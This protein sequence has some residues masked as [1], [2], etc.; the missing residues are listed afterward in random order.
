MAELLHRAV[1]SHVGTAT[2]PL[3]VPRGARKWRVPAY[4]VADV[5]DELRARG[6][7]YGAA[8]RDAPP[9]PGPPRARSRWSAPATPPTTACTTPSLGPRRCAQ[10]AASLWPAIDAKAVLARLLS[11]PACLASH[12]DGVLTAQEQHLLSGTTLPAARLGARWSAADQVLLDELADLVERTPSLG[13]VIL[14]EAQDLSPMQCARSGD[15]APPGRRRCSATSPRAPPRG[16][17]SPGRTPWSFLGKPDA[18]IDVLDRGFRVPA[19][20]I[21]Y[22]ARLLPHMAPGLGTPQSVRDNPGRLLVEQVPAGR[23][24][25]AVVA[26]TTA[27]ATEPGTVGVIVADREVA[28][29]S[30]AL[31]K[32]GVGHGM[33]GA[34]RGDVEHQIDLVPATVAKGLEFDRVIVVEPT[35]IAAAEPDERTGLRRLYVVL[36]RAVSALHVLHADDLPTPLRG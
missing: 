14:D 22:A 32:A 31:T 5:L 20:V 10:Y 9:A 16:P 11:D 28:A 34:D 35:A 3:V 17:P 23:L 36:T 30:R 13:H 6:V 27:S 7:R 15:G 4:L 12:A 21:D 18:H 33:L 8:R 24:T 25:A 19:L 26:A 1:W 29:Y 2:E